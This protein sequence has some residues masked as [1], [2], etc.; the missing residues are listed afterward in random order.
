MRHLRTW[1]IK[2]K[3]I[4]LATLRRWKLRL[5]WQRDFFFCVEIGPLLIE[6]SELPF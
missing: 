2:D 3:Y 5:V 1:R 6:F 4:H